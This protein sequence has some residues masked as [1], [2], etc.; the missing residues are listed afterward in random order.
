MTS[1][2]IDAKVEHLVTLYT[3][4]FHKQCVMYLLYSRCIAKQF[5][6][7]WGGIHGSFGQ[8]SGMAIV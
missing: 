8:V 2:F 7:Y 4:C 5:C 3:M 6:C 1:H